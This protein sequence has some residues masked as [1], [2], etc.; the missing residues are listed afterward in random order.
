MDFD[1][2]V[3]EQGGVCVVKVAG[4]IDVYT[5][6]RLREHLVKTIDGG[7]FHVVVDLSGVGFMD[8][9]GLGALVSALRRIKEKDGTIRLASPREPVMKVLSITGLDK[10]FPVFDDVE[11]AL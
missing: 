8:S 10:V 4:E 1:I 3:L 5:S 7:C 11:Q 6:P 9:S 2:E